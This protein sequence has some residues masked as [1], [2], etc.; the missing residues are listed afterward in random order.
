MDSGDDPDP[1]PGERIQRS[2]FYGLWPCF[3]E[4]EGAGEPADA[5][6]VPGFVN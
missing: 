4:D 6:P 1:D 3:T 5:E 2:V